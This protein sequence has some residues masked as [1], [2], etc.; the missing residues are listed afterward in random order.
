MK[1]QEIKDA[2]NERGGKVIE[3]LIHALVDVKPEPSEKI[4]IKA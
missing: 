4:V 3:T 1:L 2:G